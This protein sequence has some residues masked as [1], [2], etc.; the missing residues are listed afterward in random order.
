MTYAD[1][2]TGIGLNPQKRCSRFRD[3]AERQNFEPLTNV[4]D[5]GRVFCYIEAITMRSGWSPA[6]AL[7][8]GGMSAGSA[9][10]R[11]GPAHTRGHGKGTAGMA[12][13]K[14]PT[15]KPRRRLPRGVKLVN[16]ELPI[17]ILTAVEAWAAEISAR[18]DERVST[19]AVIRHLLKIALARK[20]RQ[21][22]QREATP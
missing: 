2:L 1:R 16:L 9:F 6:G 3:L 15:S 17:D 7:V 20:R 21:A 5:N 10:P 14:L 13:T 22:A 19:Q 8:V 18:S 11:I 12:R 4:S